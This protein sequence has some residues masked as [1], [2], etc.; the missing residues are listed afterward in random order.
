MGFKIS[1]D[2]ELEFIQKTALKFRLI[3]NPLHKD[4]EIRKL[5]FL[6]GY[7]YMEDFM[8]EDVFDELSD[9]DFF[10]NY[11]EYDDCDEFEVDDVYNHNKTP[12]K[13]K[14][15]N[16]VTESLLDYQNIYAIKGINVGSR[17]WDIL[18]DVMHDFYKSNNIEDLFFEDMTILNR[19]AVSLALLKSIDVDIN[20]YIEGMG[21][22]EDDYINKK[23]IIEL[24]DKITHKVESVNRINSNRANKTKIK[25]KMQN[26]KIV[27]FNS[28][29]AQR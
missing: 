7:Q 24:Q 29:K 2:D 26:G 6:N 16:F 1:I 10:D 4:R 19:F 27:D 12:Y 8:Y 13:Y 5:I 14:V 20:C 18:F 11:E 17:E 3:K 21:Y 15:Q 22:L 28:W 23:E 25:S 9:I